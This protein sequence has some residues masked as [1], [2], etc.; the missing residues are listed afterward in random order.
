MFALVAM[1]TVIWQARDADIDLTTTA[2][3]LLTGS[4]A[5]WAVTVV[6]AVLRWRLLLFDIFHTPDLSFRRLLRAAVLARAAGLLASPMLAG[7]AGRFLF[8]AK[9]V[10]TKR[11][12]IGSIA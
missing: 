1:A 6:V 8:T 9:D 7:T 5:I 11:R 3:L 2:W 12:L 4:C 10:G